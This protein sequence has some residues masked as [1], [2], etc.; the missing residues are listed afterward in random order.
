MPL[1]LEH[2]KSFLFKQRAIIIEGDTNL[3]VQALV[4]LATNAQTINQKRRK[5]KS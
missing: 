2:F 1:P 5:D 4:G 3:I